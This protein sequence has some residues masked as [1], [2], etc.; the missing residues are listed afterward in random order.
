M[1]GRAPRATIGVDVGTSGCKAALLDEHG[2]VEHTSA[3]GYET[4]RGFDG[5]ASQRPDDWLTAVTTVL[6]AASTAAGGRRIEALSITAPAHAA[7][8]VDDDGRP[9]APSLLAW[10]GRP[11]SVLPALRRDLGD[12][13]FERTFIE[14]TTGWTL[15]QLIWLRGQLGP[16][17]SRVRLVLT[18]KDYVRY[19]LTGAAATDPTDAQG[20]ALYDPTTGDWAADLVD[21][22]GLDPQQLPPI[23]PSYSIGGHLSPDWSRATGLPAGIPVSVGAT[24][25]AAELVS[26]D[27]TR[28]G[29]SLI[30]IASTGTVVVVA[31]QP[32][33]DRR[34]LT[35]PHAVAGLWYHLGATNTAATSYAWLRQTVFGESARSPAEVYAEMDA[36]A[37][38]VPP[39]AEGLLFLPFLQ[40]ERT[41]YWDPHLRGAFIGLSSAHR[42]EHFCRAVLE[43]VCFSLRT[44]RDVFEEIGLPVRLPSVGGGGSASRLWRS[45][46]VSIMGQP[47][48]LASVQ[49]P[50]LGS[51]MIAASCIGLAAP[52]VAQAEV[53]QP[54][55]AWVE[56]YEQV[57]A[58]Y[59]QAAD[60][61]AP[62]SHRLAGGASPSDSMA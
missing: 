55:T 34:T 28:P 50:A 13:L 36:Y 14:L 54:E 23:T 12:S 39:G 8:L 40:G 17:W 5:E 48:T 43:G 25:T 60:G 44:C 49:G 21:L 58:L 45:I 1:P 29:A 59:R 35:Y 41:P 22:A 11:A 53:V 38:K 51:A 62:I 7:V 10:D 42:R 30:K 18:Q 56:T 33:P 52:V 3:V 61:L 15:P 32:R 6:R 16:T 27:A 47:A 26:L 4:R 57:Y 31:E 19:R 46:L 2:R 24:D 20:M 37:A 9:L